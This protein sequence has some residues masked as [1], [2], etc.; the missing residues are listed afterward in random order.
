MS[1]ATQRESTGSELV[2]R[3][4]DAVGVVAHSAS[5]E[6]HGRGSSGRQMDDPSGRFGGEEVTV[7]SP[8]DRLRR[9]ARLSVVT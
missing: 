6:E 3:V 7:R 8:E 2:I 5:H 9:R 1:L 4:A